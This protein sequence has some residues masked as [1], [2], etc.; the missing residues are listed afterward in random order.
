MIKNLQCLKSVQKTC[1][2]TSKH[3]FRFE[4]NLAIL[5]LRT[6]KAEMFQKNSTFLLR[7]FFKCKSGNQARTKAG[8]NIYNVP[9]ISRKFQGFV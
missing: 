8:L 9:I 4:K 1:L 7:D 5:N 6:F 3:R 2:D